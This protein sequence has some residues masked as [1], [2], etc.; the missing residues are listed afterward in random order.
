MISLSLNS[1]INSLMVSVGR[2]GNDW[3]GIRG[4]T[5]AAKICVLVLLGKGS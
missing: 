3:A 4:H 5:G 1:V 2:E